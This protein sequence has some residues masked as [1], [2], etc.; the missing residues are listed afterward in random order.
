MLYNIL[1]EFSVPMEQ[2][3]LIKLRLNEVCSKVHMVNLV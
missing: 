2:V 1:I 3:G